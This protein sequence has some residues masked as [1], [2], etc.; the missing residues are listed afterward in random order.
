MIHVRTRSFTCA[1]EGGVEQGCGCPNN[2]T[3]LTVT[4]SQG[5]A[6]SHWDTDSEYKAAE[7]TH[8]ARSRTTLRTGRVLDGT[9]CFFF[10][11]EFQLLGHSRGACHL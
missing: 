11:K 10:E 7:H 4:V 9:G 1:S 8:T 6:F 5:L 3:L 2:A